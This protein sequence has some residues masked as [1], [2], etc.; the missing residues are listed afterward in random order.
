[1]VGEVL[2]QQDNVKYSHGSQTRRLQN[3]M[4]LARSPHLS[5][6]LI[7]D[8]PAVENTSPF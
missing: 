6:I 4:P 2:I 5:A 8:K 3:R 7:S 1:M